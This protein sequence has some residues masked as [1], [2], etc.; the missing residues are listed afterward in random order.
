MLHMRINIIGILSIY[1]TWIKRRP[2]LDKRL[3][4]GV[5]W[6]V[7]ISLCISKDEIGRLLTSKLRII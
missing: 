7:A 4:P 3:V 6:A 1:S 2:I 5:N